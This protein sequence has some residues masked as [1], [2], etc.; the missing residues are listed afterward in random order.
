L[1]A[2]SYNITFLQAPHHKQFTA[3][4]KYC[5]MI[6]LHLSLCN[7]TTQNVQEPINYCLIT[8][9]FLFQ[10]L[11]LKKVYKDIR[12]SHTTQKDATFHLAIRLV[13]EW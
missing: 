6:M 1:P 8:L 11:D 4:S 10:I 9:S 12:L 13:V 7:K 3:L 2:H 5:Q